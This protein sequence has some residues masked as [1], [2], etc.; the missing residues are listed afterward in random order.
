MIESPC[1]NC[2]KRG[3]GAFH[4]KCEPYQKF[5]VERKKQLNS[6]RDGSR[7]RRGEYLNGSTYKSRVGHVFKSRRT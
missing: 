1:K 3:C 4:D 5:I 6:K 7:T 2:E